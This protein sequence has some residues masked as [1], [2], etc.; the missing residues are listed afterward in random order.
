MHSYK[1]SNCIPPV[2]LT[3]KEESAQK[4]HLLVLDQQL[5]NQDDGSGSTHQQCHWVDTL[6]EQPSQQG[7]GTADAGW[8]REGGNVEKA[9]KRDQMAKYYM[10]VHTI[11]YTAVQASYNSKS[12]KIMSTSN[13]YGTWYEQVPTYIHIRIKWGRI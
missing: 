1:G 11:S 4:C 3:L 12:G 7:G 13:V 6:H 5:G 8:R 10:Y 2:H 9:R